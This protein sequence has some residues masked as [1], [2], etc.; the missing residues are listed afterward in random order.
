VLV[1]TSWL[2]L[3]GTQEV[4]SVADSARFASSVF[5]IL[6]PLQLAITIFFSSLTA[7]SSVA[8]EKDRQTLTLLLM[9]RL[10]NGQLVLGKLS[11]AL[12]HVVVMITAAV[13]VFL[14]LMLFGGISYG[15]VWRTFLVALLSA[16]AAG[17]LGSLLALWREKTFQALALTSLAIVLWLGMWE[18]VHAG[19]LGRQW[20]GV[21]TATLAVL[22]SPVRA[23]VMAASDS[24]ASLSLVAG[25]SAVT[26]AAAIVMNAL[27]IVMLRAWNPS[28]QLRPKAREEDSLESIFR[29]GEQA[30]A[31]HVDARRPAVPSRRRRRVWSNPVLWRELCTWAY[32]RKILGIRVAYVVLFTLAAAGLYA[33]QQQPAPPRTGPA[34]VRIP[35]AVQPLAPLLVVSLVIVNAL[36]VTSITGE[37]DGRALDLLLA[38]DLTPK[39]FVLGKLA[40]VLWVCKEMVVLPLL[41]CGWLWYGG[42]LSTEHLIYLALGLVV[43]YLFAAMLGIH[44]GMNY[45][46]SPAAIAVSLGTVF[47]LFL[48]VVACMM[49]MIS[50]GGSFQSQFW[51][52]FA[53]IGGGSVG[54]FVSLGLRNPS[55]AI[56]LTSV[57]LP[58]AT[59]YSITS[60]ILQKSLAVFLVTSGAYGFAVL[61]MLVPAI[62]EFDVAMGRTTVGE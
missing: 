50:L 57:A 4:R 9:T 6:A 60:F 1:C 18:A 32:G 14:L 58:F 54:L 36:A 56:L 27:G 35:P 2:V 52:F 22:M 25:F 15:Q 13:P 45:V 51:P 8:Q 29:T 20:L 3:V 47:F 7:A 30:R 26:V 59:F 42:G 61:A 23:T 40:G 41:L 53:M 62:S 12:L 17:S 55:S 39:E 33:V 10:T 16:V 43:M 49:M 31:G 21:S 5:Q 19:L 34:A 48:G 44:C 28:R 37:R 11:A 38:T 46:A 24:A